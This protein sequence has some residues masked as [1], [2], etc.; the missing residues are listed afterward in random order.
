[1]LN[2]EKGND[3]INNK[4]PTERRSEKHMNILVIDVGTSSMRGIL[5]S[6]S[7]EELTKKQYFYKASYRGEGR[8]E[9]SPS[10]W[11]SA[12]YMIVKEISA[13]ALEE[14]WKIDAIS[15]T[16]QRSSVIPMDV[17]LHPLSDAIMWQDKRA[18]EICAALQS[19][20]ERIFSLCGSR[21]NPVFS[22]GKIAWIK[23][24]QPELYR[25]TYKF[26]VIPDYLMYLMTGNICTD[27][28]YGSRSLLMNLHTC[29]WEPE[30]L[31]LFGV[32]AEKLCDLVEP[33]S[34]CGVTSKEFA[35]ITGCREG[36]PVI[37]AGGDQQCGAVGQGVIKKGI[38][39]VTAGTGGYL[40]A[41]SE[42]V[43]ENLQPD[44]V[45]NVSSVKK[46]YILEASVLTCCSAFDWFRREFYE[47]ADYEEINKVIASVSP[48]ANG[49]LCLPCFQGRSTPDWNNE[50]KG[51]FANVTLATTKKDMLRSLL[52]GIAYELGNGIENMKKYVEISSIY[53]NGGLTESEV[54][55]EIQCNVYG[56]RIV[57]RGTADATARGALMI[58]A[59]TLGMYDTVESAFDAIG[60]GDKTKA[61]KPSAEIS[62]VYARCREEMN[63]VYDR[64]WN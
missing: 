15:I 58:G 50:A 31:A 34:V 40:E 27:H 44:I 13:K 20:N 43:P 46:Q 56:T 60:Q 45:C 32:E 2:E 57:R 1:M 28:T 30:L 39:S 14:R 7:G 62:A 26:M 11:E 12:L 18:N 9:Q 17:H 10:D 47:N 36:I 35:N 59:T 21:A 42:G 6:Y 61:Y 29:E 24:H 38:L 5:L 64:M 51:M 33:G 3:K 49:C 52:E 63:R 23:K 22:G 41:S 37:T 48:G 53:V 25:D 55:N 54:F 16:A 4:S 8:V 19:E